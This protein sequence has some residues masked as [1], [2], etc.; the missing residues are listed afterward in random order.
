[1][2]GRLSIAIVSALAGPVA[3]AAQ[4]PAPVQEVVVTARDNAG[5]L[6]RRPSDTVF[7][8]KKPLLETPRSASLASAAT[9]E[10]YGIRD[11]NALT[12]VSPGAFTDSY[13]GVAGSLNL[14]G[15]LAENYFR[16]FKRIENRGTYPTPLG[17]ADRVEI[18][19]GPPAPV[20]GPG[21]V[22]GYLDFTP[23]TARTDG[24]YLSQPTGQIEATLGDYGEAR[25]T[26]QIGLPAKIGAVTG[27]V[28]LYGE[29]E[30]DTAY[31]RGIN[32]KH[33]V[34]QGSGDFDLGNG[35][36]TAFGGMVYHSTGAVQTPGWN[37]L[38]Q[39][40]VDHRTY[41]TGRNTAIVDANGDGR[42][43]PSEIGAPLE[44]GYFGFT[45]APDP[46]F[47]LNTGV[48]TTTLDRRTVFVSNRDFSDTTTQTYYADLGKD[49]G[50]GRSA[51]VQLFY[52]DLDNQRFVSY[53]FPADYQAH[54]WEARASVLSND[55]VFG[56]VIKAQSVA[57]LSYR[58]YEGRQRESFNGGYIALDRRDLSYGPTATDI[59]DDPFSTDVGGGGLTWETD[60]HSRVKDAGVFAQTD[61]KLP[62]GFDFTGGARYDDYDV[63]GRDD[64]TVVF[65]PT[66]HQTYTA[67]KG[68][69]TW[70]A[71][72]SW[73][74]PWGLMPYASYAHTAAPELTQAGGVAPN[75]IADNAWLAPSN[76]REAGVKLRLFGDAITGSLAAYRQ[77]RTDL[78]QGNVVV[79]T[80]GRG[81]EA[82]LRWVI[83][84]HFSATLAG[85]DQRTTIKGPDNS[86]VVVPPSAT[87]TRDVDGYGG[88]YA[89]FSLAQLRPGNYTDTLIPRRVVSLYGTYTSDRFE[90]GRVGGTLGVTSVSSTSG[91]IPGAV[92]FPAYG[93]V[94]GSAYVERGPWRVAANVDNLFDTFYFTPV[95]DVYSNVAVLPGVGR[96]FRVSLRRSF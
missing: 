76:L 31:Y 43:Q 10:R 6:E 93:L 83:D 80:L 11:I 48:G 94:N 26:G 15:T 85:N 58:Y 95:A 5:L 89:V 28:Y 77:T 1:M 23:K 39:A 74:S 4:T 36:S 32:P 24:G 64:G 86:F 90:W 56:G 88:T 8:I 16:G 87:G 47:V 18:V 3:T 46:R 65:S 63:S 38:T 44:V 54:V 67:S 52:D 41:Q 14:R 50:S 22:G 7:G 45:P 2:R 20:S 68:K 92:R 34:F 81:V 66:P 61:V 40:L 79:G 55:S 73:T 96:T 13:Y 51:K 42:L 75:L 59:I 29:V 82:E 27:G 49:L 25:L 57:G 91:V 30:D 72:L 33:E 17:A 70:N 60:I 84:K 78:G 9:L 62:A 53:G 69:F 21:K 71:A 12:E 35:W 19:R 37:R